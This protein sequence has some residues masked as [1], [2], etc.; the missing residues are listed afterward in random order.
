MPKGGLYIVTQIEKIKQRTAELYAM[1]PTD[2][3]ETRKS[4]LHIRDELLEIN[5]KLF[6]KIALNTHLD[7]NRYEYGD[8]HQEIC[9]QFLEIWWWYKYPPRYKDSKASFTS[10][11]WVRLKERAERSLNELSYSV[12]RSTL[13]QCQRLLGLDHWTKVKPEMLS[14]ITGKE[15]HEVVQLAMRMMNRNYY[16]AIEDHWDLE[17]PEISSANEVLF[18]YVDNPSDIKR[19]LVSEMILRESDLSGKEIEEISDI[20]CIPIPELAS[21]LEIAKIELYSKL[22]EIDDWRN[23]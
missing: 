10:Y 9:L 21:Q 16:T 3:E 1:L 4:M 13:I 6:H 14:A 23:T 8:K 15:N 19:L 22:K 18:S 2:C 17:S 12:Y 20:Y 11:M 5:E 7:H